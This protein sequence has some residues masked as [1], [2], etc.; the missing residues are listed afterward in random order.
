VTR[1]E[2]TSAARH[3]QEAD[4]NNTW[5][6]VQRGGTWIVARIGVAPSP[7]K[8]LGTATQP[9]PTAPRD[10]PQSELQRVTTQYGLFG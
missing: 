1:D 5:T 2:A 7:G 4:P 10:A 8:P 6:A 9:P 3:K